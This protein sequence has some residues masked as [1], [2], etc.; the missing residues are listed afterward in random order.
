[1]YE[2]IKLLNLSWPA[3]S[4]SCNRTVLS[5]KYM[6]WPC[7]RV[8][9]V[10]VGH[11]L[12]LERKS[13]PMVAWYMLSNESYMKRVM[14]DVLPTGRL[15]VSKHGPLLPGAWHGTAYRS[16]PRGRRVCAVLASW[17]RPQHGR[18]AI[19]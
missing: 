7:Q 17:S 19:T 5:S 11:L 10:G 3:V 8:W 16:V 15:L 1:M 13:M 9:Y 6:V 2:G 4:Q 18:D 14:S 12:A